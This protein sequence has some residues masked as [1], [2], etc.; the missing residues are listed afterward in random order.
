MMFRRAWD[1]FRIPLKVKDVKL[2][3]SLQSCS[4][5][6]EQENESGRSKGIVSSSEVRDF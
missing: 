6:K 1:A 4:R 2:S 3:Q 5:D